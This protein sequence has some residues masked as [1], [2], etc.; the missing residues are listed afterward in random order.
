MPKHTPGPW[1]FIEDGRTE[2]EH[3]VG[4]PLTIG[5][6]GTLDDLANVFSHDDST[7]SVPREEA[8]ANARLISAAPDLLIAAKEAVIVIAS[9]AKARHLD[10]MQGTCMPGLIKAIKKAEGRS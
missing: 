8:V 5:H 6:Y 7:V 3:N 9:I 2:D 1:R 4:K 10:P